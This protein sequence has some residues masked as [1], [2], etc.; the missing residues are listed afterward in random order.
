MEKYTVATWATAAE[1]SAK[2]KTE[3]LGGLISLLSADI[4]IKS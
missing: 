1:A 4:G 3:V 2:K